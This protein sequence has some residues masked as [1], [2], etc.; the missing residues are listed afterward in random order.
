MESSIYQKAASI[1]SELGY[2]R[3]CMWQQAL[4]LSDSHGFLYENAE[5]EQQPS[6]HCQLNRFY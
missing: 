6:Q 5:Q 4:L 1:L 3:T 2:E